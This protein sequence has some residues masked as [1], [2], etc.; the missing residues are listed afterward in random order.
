MKELFDQNL[1]NFELGSQ[2]S[3][4]VPIWINVGFQQRWKQDSQ[5]VSNDTFCRLSVTSAQCIIG[6]EKNLD[7]GILINFDK[8]EYSQGYAQIKEVFSG[9][10]KGDILQSSMSDDKFRSSNVMV[11]DF[12]Y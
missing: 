2:K 5:N 1:W 3:M 12:G 11:D 10:T 8:D 4:N 7:G 9:L 6:T